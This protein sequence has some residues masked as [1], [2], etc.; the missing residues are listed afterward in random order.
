[1]DSW[2]NNDYTND[3]VLSLWTLH[4]DKMENCEITEKDDIMDKDNI[5]DIKN[6]NWEKSKIWC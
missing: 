5:T 3:Y 6:D 4:D 2:V 1:M